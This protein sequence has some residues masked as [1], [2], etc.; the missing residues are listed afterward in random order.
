MIKIKRVKKGFT[1]VEILVS[2]AIIILFMGVLTK[3]LFDF[4]STSNRNLTISTM[5]MDLRKAVERLE[6][7]ISP[8]REIPATLTVNGVTYTTSNK[9][10]AL[11]VPAYDGNGYPLFEPTTSAD[12]GKPK[13]DLVG[14][15]IVQ[16]ETFARVNKVT[17]SVTKESNMKLLFSIQ[18]VTGSKRKLINN[19]SLYSFL[20][21]VTTTGTTPAPGTYSTYP[22]TT[23][24]LFNF[25]DSSGNSTSTYTQARVIKIILRAEKEFG[26]DNYT[27]K[28]ETEIRL[29][30]STN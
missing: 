29:R 17:G 13:Y 27:V 7:E 6:N 28:R 14:L 15:K 25:F 19:Q 26:R 21:P 24:M 20:S 1:L 4:N 5:D 10:I 11:K 9:E 23:D 3:M 8:A 18:P 12:A 30:N 22:S 2:L 16:G